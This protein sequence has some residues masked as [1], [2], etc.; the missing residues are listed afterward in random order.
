MLHYSNK[1]LADKIKCEV[2]PDIIRRHSLNENVKN[3]DIFSNHDFSEM[4]ILS[5]KVRFVCNE[6]YAGA[7]FVD[8]V[9]SYIGSFSIDEEVIVYHN[10]LFPFVSLK[11]T[12]SAYEFV[13]KNPN[14]IIN[15]ELGIISDSAIH[16]NIDLGAVSVFNF[17]TL[18][19]LGTR[20]T[21]CKERIELTTLEMLC[22]RYLDDLEHYNLI[23]NSGF[24]V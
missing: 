19:R 5:N 4:E 10:P 1:N 6:F 14:C 2:I 12:F 7:N 3:I 8:L 11:K 22:L 13:K 20:N 18:Q 23:I 9:K 15:A 16:Q 24:K 17:N 21:S